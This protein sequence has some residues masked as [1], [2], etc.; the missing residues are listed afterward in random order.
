MSTVKTPKKVKLVISFFSGSLETLDTAKKKLE[1]SFGKIDYQ[2]SDLLFKETDYY[3]NEMGKNL[4]FKIISFKKLISRSALP[5]IKHKCFKIEKK[6][7]I[8]DKGILK[9]KVNID[10]GIVT[11]ENFVL[12]TGKGYSHRIYLNKGIYAD[13]TLIYK[14]KSYNELPWTYLNYKNEKIKKILLDIRKNYFNKLKEK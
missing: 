6:F 3:E 13:L 10:P 14:G 12:A 7:S 2:S 1:K 11:L 5:V 8:K 9:R 4:I